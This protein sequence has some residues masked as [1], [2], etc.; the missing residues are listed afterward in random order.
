MW[1]SSIALISNTLLNIF[2]F[3]ISLSFALKPFL[4]IIWTIYYIVGFYF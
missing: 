3:K 2:F 4:L 1:S